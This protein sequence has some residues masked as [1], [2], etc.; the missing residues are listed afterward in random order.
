MVNSENTNS[1]LI[2]SDGVHTIMYNLIGS[3]L[4]ICTLTLSMWITY[5]FWFDR[6]CWIRRKAFLKWLKVNELPEPIIIKKDYVIW[7]INDYRITKRNDGTCYIFEGNNLILS[8]FHG[9]IIDTY[10]YKKIYN[11]LKV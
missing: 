5:S 4:G 11:Y 6:T 8:S 7:F 3:I 10:I 9:G 2:M 1:E